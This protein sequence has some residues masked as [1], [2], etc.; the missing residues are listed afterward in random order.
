M[1]KDMAILALIAVT[2]LTGPLQ[3]AYLARAI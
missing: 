2:Q 1:W 3:P